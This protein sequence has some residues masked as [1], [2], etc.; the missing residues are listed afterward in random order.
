MLKAYLSVIHA[1][2]ILAD[3]RGYHALHA[4]SVSAVTILS[5]LLRTSESDDDG[6]DSVDGGPG[7][8]EGID[9]AWND[10]GGAG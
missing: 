1:S 2:L 6:D 5:A 4:T 10:G 9:E 7:S 8:Y 3:M